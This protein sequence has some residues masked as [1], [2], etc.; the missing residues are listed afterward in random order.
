MVSRDGQ[1]ARI[2]LLINIGTE[3]VRERG[4]EKPES[5][6]SE[7]GAIDEPFFAKPGRRSGTDTVLELRSVSRT[8]SKPGPSDP[9]FL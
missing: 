1:K 7:E 9:K 6:A 3:V 4:E 5:R 2:A 8:N